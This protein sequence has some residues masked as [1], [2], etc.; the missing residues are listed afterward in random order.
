MFKLFRKFFKLYQQDSK[1]LYAVTFRSGFY[2]S[3]CSLGLYLTQEK[4]NALSDQA[5]Y[6]YLM[7]TGGFCVGFAALVA[8]Y[9]TVSSY[10][11]RYG[12]IKLD[13]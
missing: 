13:K 1:I 3:G 12:E 4:V 7:T 9:R 5:L 11:A 6:T 10:E 2:L 8:I